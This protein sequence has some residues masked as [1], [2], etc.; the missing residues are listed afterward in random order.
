MSGRSRSKVDWEP[1]EDEIRSLFVDRD[2]T[3][4]QVMEHMKTTYGFEATYVV[5]S[6]DVRM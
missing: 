2:W 3:W 4:K 5:A 1:H 6:I